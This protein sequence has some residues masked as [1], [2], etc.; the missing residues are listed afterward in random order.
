MLPVSTVESPEF[1]KL[2]SG[3]SSAKVLLPDWKSFMSHVDFWHDETQG[4]DKVC[5]YN[6]RCVYIHNKIVFGMMV[7]WINPNTLQHCKAA[8]SCTRLVGRHIYDVLASKIESIHRSYNLTGKVTA[9]ATDHGSNFVKAFKTFYVTYLTSISTETVQ[10]EYSLE[11]G[12]TD[13]EEA[14]SDDLLTLD[15]MDDLTQV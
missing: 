2:I 3:V 9:T 12:C 7:H 1:R 4:E 10:E 13:K 14:T 5:V 6:S 15:N 8:I 11:D